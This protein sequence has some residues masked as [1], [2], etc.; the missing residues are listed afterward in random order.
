MNTSIQPRPVPASPRHY[1]MHR[2]MAA[3]AA[4]AVCLAAEAVSITRYVAEGATGDG[5]TRENPTGNLQEVLDMSGRV[6]GITVYLAPGTYRLRPLEDVNNR[7]TYRNVL[8]YGGGVTDTNAAQN[9]SVITGDMVVNGG[10]LCNVDFRGSRTGEPAQGYIYG[11]LKAIGCN[12]YHCNV[13]RLDFQAT[14]PD[15]QYLI[16]VRTPYAQISRYGFYHGRPNVT[17]TDCSFSGGEGLSLSGVKATVSGCNFTDNTLGL[18]IKDADG[19]V[20]SDCRFTSNHK[21]GAIDIRTLTDDFAAIFDRCVIAGNVTTQGDNAPGITS[22]APYLI[23]NSLIAKNSSQ[24][25]NG[26]NVPRWGAVVLSRRQ[27]RIWNCTFYDNKDAAIYYKM[28]PGDQPR[29]GRNQIVNCV[30]L[31]NRLSYVAYYDNSPMMSYCAADFGS[32]IPELDAENHMIRIDETTA[33]MQVGADYRVTVEEGSPLINAGLPMAD[34]DLYRVER[35][36]LGGTD[37]GC[38]EHK[39]TWRV[40]VPATT[41]AFGHAA[42]TKCE[43]THQGKRYYGYVFGNDIDG[44]RVEIANNVYLGDNLV[45]VKLYDNGRVAVAAMNIAGKK[46]AVLYVLDSAVWTVAD[47]KTYTSALPAAVRNGNT[48]KL[49]E[50]ATAAPK[51]PVRRNAPSRPV[52][53]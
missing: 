32:G 53:R 29:V 20:F 47:A 12:L 23:K 45:P 38:A 6:D 43:A 40:S 7:T 26:A 39:G 50:Q 3:L 33:G 48:W 49:K 2:I 8:I 41:L 31:K 5:L 44:D 22:I 11:E 16:G 46:T 18:W 19:T 42:Y 4:L 15:Q 25:K 10:A 21:Y 37:I 36:M 27:T 52:R 30:F 9:K 17:V 13:S 24:V 28:A 51:A 14:G 34:L 35:Q 1:T